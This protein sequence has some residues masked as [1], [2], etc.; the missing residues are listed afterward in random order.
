MKYLTAKILPKIDFAHTFS[1]DSYRL[2]I[3]PKPNTIEIAYISKGSLHFDTDG[4]DLLIKSGSI[5]LNPY[6]RPV[7]FHSDEYHEHHTVSF[8]MEFS[9]SDLPESPSSVPLPSVISSPNERCYRL[10]DDIIRIHTLNADSGLKTAGMCLQ[11]LYEIGAN[12]DRLDI[13]PYIK[14]VK[15]YVFRHLNEPIRQA[16]IANA[17]GITPE[18]LCDVFK[19]CENTTVMS[20]V[21]RVKLDKIRAVMEKEHLPL[22]KASELYGYADPN[23]VSRLYKKIFHTNIS[24]RIKNKDS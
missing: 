16:D 22:Y 23:Y 12:P 24:D 3:K 18:Y 20:Y 6:L 2:K 19:R 21:N 13:S 17:L 8:L 14:K 9:L 10:I 5:V 15:N 7:I 1:A 4:E 11:L